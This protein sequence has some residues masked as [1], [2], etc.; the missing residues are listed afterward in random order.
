MLLLSLEFVQHTGVNIPTPAIKP[1]RLAPEVRTSVL[2][3]IQQMA[4]LATLY[5]LLLVTVLAL[6]QQV[7][8]PLKGRIMNY[9]TFSVS[10]RIFIISSQI[11]KHPPILQ[12]S[13]G[14]SFVLN[15]PLPC[16]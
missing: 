9:R 3:F 11:K 10:K 4:S 13:G 2:R 1:F 15:S 5:L 7:E 6:I 16:R 12:L 14:G 8:L